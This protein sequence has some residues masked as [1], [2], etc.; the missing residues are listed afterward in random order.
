VRPGAA[1]AVRWLFILVAL[2]GVV[3]GLAQVDLP[4]AYLLSAF[5]VGIAYALLARPVDVGGRCVDVEAGSRRHNG[6]RNGG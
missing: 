3:T 5:I 6:N 4:S 1:H 2:V